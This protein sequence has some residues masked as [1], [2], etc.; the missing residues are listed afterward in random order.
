MNSVDRTRTADSPTS[1][2][3]KQMLRSMIGLLKY[4]GNSRLS[5]FMVYAD[6]A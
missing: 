5:I 4:T 3:I 6:R 2:S 1:G